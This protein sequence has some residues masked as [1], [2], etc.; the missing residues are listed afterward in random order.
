MGRRLQCGLGQQLSRQLPF[1]IVA[2]AQVIFKVGREV[3]SQLLP[4]VSNPLQV[5]S[6]QQMLVTAMLLPLLP[7]P[8][9]I[10]NPVWQAFAR[11][12]MIH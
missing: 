7:F 6:I 8:Q 2:A 9:N 3:M 11:I 5:E 10:P 12:V 1:A 4:V